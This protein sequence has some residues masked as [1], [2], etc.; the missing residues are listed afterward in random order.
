MAGEAASVVCEEATGTSAGSNGQL[1][2]VGG[3]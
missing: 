2:I 3:S 1:A